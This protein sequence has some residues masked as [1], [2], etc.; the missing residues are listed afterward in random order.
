MGA[1]RAKALRISSSTIPSVASFIWANAS[2]CNFCQ[3]GRGK[4]M[5]VCRCKRRPLRFLLIQKEKRDRV[6][7]GNGVC[8]LAQGI[9]DRK[10]RELM[11]PSKQEGVFHARK[12]L[13]YRGGLDGPGTHR[14]F[15]LN[16]DRNFCSTG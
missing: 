2:R 5:F 15:N 16:S 8:L 10:P 9:R 4:G 1:L 13:V 3:S 14:Q 12:Y 7:Q 11:T 6:R